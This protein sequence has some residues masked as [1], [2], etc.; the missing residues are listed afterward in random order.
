ME[1]HLVPGPVVLSLACRL[2]LCLLVRVLP[3]I[4]GLHRSAE[5][6]HRVPDAGGPAPT[7]GR[8]TNDGR[9]GGMVKTQEYSAVIPFFNF[10]M[11]V[12]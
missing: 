1:Y 5:T 6:D 3:A 10:I 4:R 11:D 2:L 9:Q 12:R 7:G 8:Q